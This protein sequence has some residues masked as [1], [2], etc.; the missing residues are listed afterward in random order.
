[1]FK[2]PFCWNAPPRYCILEVAAEYA[3]YPTHTVVKVFPACVDTW[4][5]KPDPTW[6]APPILMSI[7]EFEDEASNPLRKT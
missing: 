1:V 3:T 4:K 7:T 6:L 5:L 2:I